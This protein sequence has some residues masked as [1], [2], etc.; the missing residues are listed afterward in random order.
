MTLE[1]SSIPPSPGRTVWVAALL[2]VATIALYARVYDHAFINF[3]DPGYVSSNAHVKAGLSTENIMWAF[4]TGAQS[5]WHPLTWLSLM[6]DA[7]LFGA[8]PGGFHL[9]S[10]ALHTANVVM[11]FLLLTRTTGAI[12]RSA[13]VAALFAVH[14]MH[15][16]SVAWVAERKD[17]LSAF[18][19]LA[20]LLAYVSYARAIRRRIAWYALVVALYVFGLLS[21]PMLVTLP[22][23]MLLLDWWPLRRARPWM[24]VIEKLPLIALAIVASVVTFLVQEAG[25]QVGSA[26]RYPLVGRISNALVA[27]V[28]YIGK[29]FWPRDLAIFYPYP[30]AA[31]AIAPVMGAAALLLA[32]T[33]VVL[34]LARRWRYL[35]AGWLWYLGMLVPV[36][37]IV[38]V[39]RQSMADRY[40]YLP[41]I[42]LFILIT[43]TFADLARHFGAK[44]RALAA[45]GVIVL[46]AFALRTSHQ[47]E[48]WRDSKTLF[49]SAIAAAGENE[50]AEHQLANEFAREK[51]FDEA[52]RH[53]R[54]A[55]RIN[56]AYA[57]AHLNYGK[58]LV[59]QRRYDEAIA[60]LR[61]ALEFD[62]KLREA[63]TTLDLMLS[64]QRM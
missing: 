59:N 41:H 30:R 9:T 17:V 27:Y 10:V 8:W 44:P 25:G 43:W 35:P 37:G 46:L 13:F 60:E 45:V 49:T 22:F 16:E 53:Y 29:T 63:Q 55:L 48:Q 61:R 1:S 56:P 12:G 6:L 32:I 54:E 20:T 5:N 4:S 31:F 26:E 47:L 3:D 11:V 36:I 64:R 51:D 19:G 50:L 18:F 21:K 39:G 34:I 38:Q 40:S 14:P 52:N 58:S 2:A 33:I 42:G 57:K 28:R 23:A 7:N 15:V 62:P 24:L